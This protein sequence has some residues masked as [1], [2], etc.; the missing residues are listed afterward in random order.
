MEN[1]QAEGQEISQ[2]EGHFTIFYLCPVCQEPNTQRLDKNLHRVPTGQCIKCREMIP[3]YD[4]LSF[5]GPQNHNNLYLHCIEY[6]CDECGR[7]N[8][9]RNEIR[10][11]GM[12]VRPSQDPSELWKPPEERPQERMYV[13]GSQVPEY[14]EC[15]H[16]G[17]PHNVTY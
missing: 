11:E 9:I 10:R 8:F 12:F 2:A 13:S 4:L 6:I 3:F 17:E 15:D 5:Y 7:V 16:C 1:S 14:A